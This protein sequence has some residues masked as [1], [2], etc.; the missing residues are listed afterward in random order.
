MC[1]FQPDM[2]GAVHARLLD[3]STSVREAAIELVGKFILIRPELTDQ[4]FTMLS[5]RI[6]VSTE[7]LP[8]IIADDHGSW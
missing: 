8:M 6:L 3:Q 2:Q 1:L 7:L 4:Y 5:D